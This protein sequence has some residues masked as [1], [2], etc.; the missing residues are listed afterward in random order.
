MAR[1]FCNDVDQETKKT[2]SRIDANLFTKTIG[3]EFAMIL[4]YVDDLFIPRPH[5]ESNEM[6]SLLQE[7][8]T[9]KQTGELTEGS[10]VQFLG[11][12]IKRDLDSISFSTLTNYVT[13][14]VDLL[15]IT[16][17]RETN[18]R[19]KFTIPA[20][21]WHNLDAK[22]SC[23]WLATLRALTD[24]DR[25]LV[26][27]SVPLSREV[28]LTNLSFLTQWSSCYV[29]ALQDGEPQFLAYV[30]DHT[31]A[32]VC[33]LFVSSSS[34]C[35]MRT[36]RDSLS[37]LSIY[38]TFPLSIPLYLPALPTAFHLPLPWCRGLQPRALPLRSWVL[39]T[40]RTPPQ[41]VQTCPLECSF[42]FPG[43]VTCHRDQMQDF[44]QGGWNFFFLDL[45]LVQ[46]VT[47]GKTQWLSFL[48]DT[49]E[50]WTHL[51]VESRLR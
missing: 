25:R 43:N 17:N 20:V 6:L 35:L 29:Y 49:K 3:N 45:R 15:D 27:P 14:L 47:R 33:A 4:V 7:H 31:V 10:E 51:R 30:I 12:T 19:I 36:L 2:R 38:L 16:D 1:L 32:Q 8:F 18:H 28:S 46:N 44:V 42:R 9:M 13:A 23:S 37:D 5:G 21:W 50:G 24:L 40:M 22:K 39:R 34:P 48:L 11:R 26:L 41:F